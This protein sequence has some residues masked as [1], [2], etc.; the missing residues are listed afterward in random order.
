MLISYYANKKSSPR[1]PSWQPSLIS[2]N[3]P[4]DS[5][6]IIKP[7]TLK[8]FQVPILAPGLLLAFCAGNSPVTGEFPAQRLVTQVFDVFF[9][10]RLNKRWGQQWWGWW[11][12]TPPCP[13]W[14]HSNVFR[15]VTE[16]NRF[17]QTVRKVWMFHLIY[18]SSHILCHPFKI[19]THWYGEYKIPIETQPHFQHDYS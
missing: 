10:L 15:W 18:Y 9:D 19:L 14:R 11:F 1:L 13:L 3:R 17:C 4:I 16:M 7:C 12:E 5:G 8:H 6:S 2:F